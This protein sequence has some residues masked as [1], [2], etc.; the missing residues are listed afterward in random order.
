MNLKYTSLFLM[1][2]FAIARRCQLVSR[3]AIPPRD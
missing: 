3:G 1:L 2:T